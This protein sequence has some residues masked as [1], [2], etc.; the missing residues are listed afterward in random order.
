MK[1]TNEARPPNIALEPSPMQLETLERFPCGCV[2]AIQRVRPSGVTAV[3]LEAKG[4]HC[5]YREHRVNRLIRLG[6]PVESF[7]ALDVLPYEEA[8]LPV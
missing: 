4:P 1:A 2:V 5:T 7:D 3:S 6:E 8:A